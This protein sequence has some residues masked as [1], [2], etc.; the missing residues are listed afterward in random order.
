MINSCLANPSAYYKELYVLITFVC[1]YPSIFQSTFGQTRDFY[2]LV[3]EFN[4]MMRFYA[5][6]K[7]KQTNCTIGIRSDTTI[8][9][10][11]SEKRQWKR[12]YLVICAG[13]ADRCDLIK[14]SK[15]KFLSCSLNEFI[16]LFHLVKL[17]QLN[18][19]RIFVYRWPKG[20]QS[21]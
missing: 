11:S 2:F 8:L 18:K 6:D 7:N 14:Q 5:G 3:T 20:K 17:L 9:V 4:I 15:L 13:F 21:T 16:K 10:F 1:A 19:I 12:L